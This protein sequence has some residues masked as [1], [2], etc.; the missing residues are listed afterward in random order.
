AQY[1]SLKDPLINMTTIPVMIIGVLGIYFLKGQDLSMFTIIGVVMLIG[2]VINNG[3]LLVDCTNLLRSRG[4][5][6]MEAC[7]EGGASRFRPVLMTAG[8]TI[9]G[10]IPMAF[11]GTENAGLTQPIGLAVLG[12][13]ITATFITLVIVPVIYYVTNYRGAK[14]AGTL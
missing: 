5:G 2:I 13:M 11:M 14:K 12:G 4:A 3:I 6:L 1:E 10:E 7:I 9:V 8:T